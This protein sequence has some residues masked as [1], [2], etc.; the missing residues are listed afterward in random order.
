MTLGIEA[1]TRITPKQTTPMCPFPEKLSVVPPTQSVVAI[2]I[3]IDIPFTEVDK[4]V[5]AQL[6]GR[7]FPEDGSGSVNVT[8]K[9]AQVSASGD[10]LLISLLLNAKEKNSFF[11]IG[12]EATVHVWGKPVLD[13]AN[14][15]LRLTN[16]EMGV[17]SEAAF[18]LLGAAARAVMPHLQKT[19]AEKTAV[20]LKPFLGDAQKMIAS[21]ISDLQKNEDNVRVT[22]DITNLALADIA[23]DS[24]T[25]RL[26]AEVSG[27]INVTVASLPGL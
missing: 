5:E 15:I 1:E 21:A 17:E 11:A 12:G 3:P 16:V 25:L 18:G 10:R 20:D 13:K 2:D 7:T 9:R 24:K 27:S 8:V 23:Y 6:I 4:L 14:Q 22:T 26:I 19:L